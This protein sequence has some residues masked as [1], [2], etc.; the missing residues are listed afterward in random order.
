MF[1]LGDQ[2]GKRAT[3]SEGGD[4]QSIRCRSYSMTA[5]SMN[6]ILACTNAQMVGWSVEVCA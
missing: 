2:E 5:G 4:Y 1:V 6:L 3:L